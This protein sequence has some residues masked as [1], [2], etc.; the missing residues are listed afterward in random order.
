MK[1]QE[2]DSEIENIKE[3]LEEEV[4]KK[5]GKRK[6]L[7]ESNNKNLNP[8]PNPN[9]N[10]KKKTKGAKIIDCLIPAVAYTPTKINNV[11]FSF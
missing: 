7:I 11:I 1:I 5:K 10:P 4:E 6:K 9:P 3:K 2:A 8:N